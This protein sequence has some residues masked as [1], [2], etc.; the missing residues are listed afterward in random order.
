MNNEQ[1]IERIKRIVY[2]A[3]VRYSKLLRLNQGMSSRLAFISESLLTAGIGDKKQAVKEAF[4]KLKT[5]LKD[6]SDNESW[7]DENSG[8]G[9]MSVWQFRDWVLKDGGKIDELFTEL[10]GAD[11]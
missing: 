3:D 2:E 9:L 1:E 5:V 8:D 7:L 10:Y 4:E 11:E 6:Y